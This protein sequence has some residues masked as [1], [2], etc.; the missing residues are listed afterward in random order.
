MRRATN[1][2]R[3][4]ALATRASRIAPDAEA[5][6]LQ[7]QMRI[8]RAGM[9]HALTGMAHSLPR[10]LDPRPWARRY[11]LAGVLVSLGAGIA[12]GRAVAARRP[13]D[14]RAPS[15]PAQRFERE[16]G[17]VVGNGCPVAAADRP[18]RLDRI[19]AGCTGALQSVGRA[20]VGWILAEMV[21]R[22]HRMSPSL[23]ADQTG[24]PGSQTP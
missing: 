8:G 5:R 16:V 21:R 13:R 19:L 9:R 2:T 18:T 23:P 14:R 22:R 6:Y 15:P 17:P 4:A 24:A 11:P 7:E 3:P 20:L 1:D 12:T 10:L